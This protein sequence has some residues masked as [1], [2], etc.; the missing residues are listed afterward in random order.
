MVEVGDALS[1]FLTAEFNL[2]AQPGLEAGHELPLFPTAA[3]AAPEGMD[4]TVLSGPQTRKQL[5]QGGAVRS[6]AGSRRAEGD[7]DA[8]LAGQA[9]IPQAMPSTAS[10]ILTAATFPRPAG[11][12]A[13]SLEGG[14][15]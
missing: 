12:A 7:G 11:S 3:G 13:T 5:E 14:Q 9:G 4:P 2:V 10:A 15:G 8:T 6:A 1:P